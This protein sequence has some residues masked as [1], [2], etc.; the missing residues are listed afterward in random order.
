YTTPSGLPSFPT[1]RSSDLWVVAA[2]APHELALAVEHLQ[3]HGAALVARQVILHDRAGGRVG[4]ERLV[5]R[6]R[7]IGPGA[8]AH[9]IARCR[10]DE[11]GL[12]YVRAAQLP[13]PR[14]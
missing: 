12:A 10:M 8:A 13:Q 7:G 2:V 6:D 3:R 1:R 11:D 9:P 14:A 4:C 5:G